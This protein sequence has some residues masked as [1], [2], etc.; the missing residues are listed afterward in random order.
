MSEVIVRPEWRTDEVPLLL[1]GKTLVVIY[2]ND[3]EFG[4]Y[5][6]KSWDVYL[7]NYWNDVKDE[8]IKGWH[9]PPEI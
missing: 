5:N 7:D 6:G 1:R 9:L 3:H 8:D 2:N 4:L